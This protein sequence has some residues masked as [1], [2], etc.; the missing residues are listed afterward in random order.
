MFNPMPYQGYQPANANVAPPAYGQQPA[1]YAQFDHGSGG[2]RGGGKGG[3]DRLPAMPSW[4]DAR[5]TK[6]EE[7]G[8]TDKHEDVE[9]GHLH[10]QAMASTVNLPQQKSQT[11]TPTGYTGPDFG[12]G[13]GAGHAQPQHQQQQY[14]G[15]DFSS[16]TQ[17]QHSTGY[18]AY[19]PS[20][21]TRYEPT[22]ANEPQ[23]LGTTSSNPL[24]QPTPSA[25]QGQGSNAPSILQAGRRPGGQDHG[26]WRDV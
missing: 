2:Y 16:P 8:T 4:S 18:S 1:Q 3:E 15:P 10:K 6:V 9:M 20:E 5:E 22:Y 25:Q 26:A 14:T 21:S 24:P 23:E 13:A 12:A 7:Y 19:A 11:E 17:Y